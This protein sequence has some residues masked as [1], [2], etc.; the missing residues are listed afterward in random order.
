MKKS[1]ET[2]LKMKRSA[3]ERWR[4]KRA[5]I[6]SSLDK[7][8]EIA[9]K[10][11]EE[12]FEEW[13]VDVEDTLFIVDALDWEYEPIFELQFREK[14]LIKVV[15]KAVEYMEKRG[16]SEVGIWCS[17][18]E[19]VSAETERTGNVIFIKKQGAEYLVET[20]KEW[21]KRLGGKCDRCAKIKAGT[22]VEVEVI[23]K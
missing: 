9:R 17:G 11:V 22:K 18:N 10:E 19:R 12:L 4:K 13:D 21:N 7:A 20:H 6:V 5:G 1:P 14:G 8:G 3:E 16:V 23:E 15:K 2:I